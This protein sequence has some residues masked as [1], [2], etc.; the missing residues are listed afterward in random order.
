[1]QNFQEKRGWKHIFKTKAFLIFLTIII[2]FFSLN[3]FSIFKEMRQTVK[4]KRVAEEKVLE[5]M[6]RKEKLFLDI[7]K[8]ETE[9]GK[10]AIFRENF[11]F[12][13]P[14][15]EMILIVEDKKSV[16]D[17]PEKEKFIFKNIFKN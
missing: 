10:E 9:K 14:G 5:L 8:L 12:S 15:E 6:D 4:K 17:F 3:I 11:G 13:K 2:I 7:E 16:E 1:M